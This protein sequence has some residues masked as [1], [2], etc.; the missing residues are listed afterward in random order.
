MEGEEEID[1]L[2]ASLEAAIDDPDGG[3]EEVSRET[4]EPIETDAEVSA[5]E[6]DEH[7]RFKAK[8]GET[9][10]GSGEQTQSRERGT[11]GNVADGSDSVASDAVRS[12]A[13]E[14]DLKAP[15]SWSP[16]A[17]EKWNAA[18]PEIQQEV[19]KRERE[20]NI[21][22]QGSAEARR[23]QETVQG[24]SQ[25]YSA[26]LQA[27][28]VDIGTATVNVL[29]F[30]SKLRFGTPI[31]KAQQIAGAIRHYGID[32]N[33]LDEAISNG[34]RQ[35]PAQ[36]AP[37]Q[38]RD[39]RLDGLM[40]ELGQMEQARNQKTVAEVTEFIGQQE[41]GQDVRYIMADILDVAA[42]QN[43][44][45]TLQDAYHRAELMHPEVSKVIEQ[46]RGAGNA[47]S[48][49]AA[50]NAASSVRNSPSVKPTGGEGD[51]IRDAILNAM[52]DS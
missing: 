33:M 11:D 43:L 18:P 7:G 23:T 6:R 44:P 41:F 26:A 47:Q 40:A 13:G 10:E 3:T 15:Q 38:F 29:E 37:Q 2:R 51:S 27:E 36:A 8:A 25:R 24:L 1:D 21:A 9:E 50:R 28:G 12:L 16:L 32:I 48:T 5:R 31:E 52:Q 34:P 35:Q 19:M 45:M 39:S 49:Q 42:S 30:A 46:R 17:R 20:I 4:A 22:M 14:H